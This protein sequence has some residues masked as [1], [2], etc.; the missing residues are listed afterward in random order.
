M[1]NHGIDCDTDITAECGCLKAL[2]FSFVCRY[3]NRMTAAEAAHINA[4]GLYIVSVY[5]T[6]PTHYGYF[7]YAQGLH[8]ANLASF[9]SSDIKQPK[10]TPIYFPVDYDA[11]LAEAEGNIGQY[12]AGI[13][14]V[15]VGTNPAIPVLHH[16][17]AY[18]NGAVLS[19]LQR[20]NQAQYTWLSM[21]RLWNGSKEYTAWNI[22]Q[23]IGRRVCGVYADYDETQ[24]NGGGWK[25]YD[26][27][28][29]ELE[30]ALA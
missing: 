4:Q 21:S 16:V 27:I 1:I 9:Y 3:I 23:S 12:F 19:T 30:K 18:G 2:G 17:G 28:L 7:S 20:N 15:L 11:T 22:K 6:A 10:L 13:N 26:S 24:G 25:A 29:A 8:D 14:K 5:E